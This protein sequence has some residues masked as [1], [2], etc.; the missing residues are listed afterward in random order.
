VTPSRRGRRSKEGSKG[1]LGHR[2]NV[3]NAKEMRLSLDWQNG[4]SVPAGWMCLTDG[5]S[6][7]KAR[8]LDRGE[9]YRELGTE[10]TRSGE[11][12]TSERDGTAICLFKQPNSS[13]LP[14][15]FLAFL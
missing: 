9:E 6:T 4:E 14:D 2:N 10:V 3:M 15:L 13:K 11:R 1:G 12:G 7:F 5:T 8:G